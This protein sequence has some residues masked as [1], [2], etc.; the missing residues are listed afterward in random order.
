MS[1][2]TVTGQLTLTGGQLTA[3]ETAAAAPSA[4]KELW[5]W[6]FNSASGYLGDGTAINRSSPVQIGSLTDWSGVSGASANSDSGFSNAIKI[7]G[8]LWSWGRGT[9]GRL[10]DGTTVAKNSPVQI[11]ALTDWSVVSAGTAHANA[12]KT[13]GTLW[14]WGD[15][16][17]HGRI[18]DGTNID[19]SSPVQIGNLS[20]WSVI[21]CGANHTHA[22]KTD[23]TLW[24]WGY[25]AQGQLG[26]GNT[27]TYS[28]PVQVGVLT[29]WASLGVGNFH[30]LAIKT[31]GTLWAWGNNN[32]RLGDGTAIDRSSPVQIGS[33]TDWSIAAGA[34]EHSHAIKTNG[35]L[36]SWGDAGSFG[37]LGLGNTTD[38]SSPVQVGILTDW[39]DVDGAS[40]H[41]MALKTDGTLWAWGGGE[42]GKL[43]LGNTTNYNSPVQVGLLTTWTSIEASAN[44]TVATKTS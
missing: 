13:D 9:D 36:W 16:T 40:D 8:T 43:G 6:G 3:K 27:T 34:R 42:S 25:S 4:G 38:Y 39:A 18:G 5:T 14:G 35:S 1:K 24:T 2:I 41:A 7:D 28:S 23:G 33:L 17:P 29:D 15:T 26:L 11:G 20:T 44:H 19:R 22:I 12:I 37:E 31:N 30:T 32:S 10:G 21:E